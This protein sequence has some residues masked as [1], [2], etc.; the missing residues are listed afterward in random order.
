MRL[1]NSPRIDDFDVGGAVGLGGHFHGAYGG[2][3]QVKTA[4]SGDRSEGGLVV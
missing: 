1:P 3:V 4:K 2:A